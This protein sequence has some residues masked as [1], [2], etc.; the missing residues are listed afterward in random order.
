MSLE[1]LLPNLEKI[2]PY[3]TI[4][5]FFIEIAIIIYQV[6]KW[7]QKTETDREEKKELGCLDVALLYISINLLSHT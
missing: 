7:R 5:S 2:L 3:L 6:G 4:I 1:E